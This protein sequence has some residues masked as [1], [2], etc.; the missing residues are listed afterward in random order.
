MVVFYTREI[1]SSIIMVCVVSRDLWIQRLKYCPFPILFQ[2]SI[3][4][5]DYCSF[6]GLQ[7][8]NSKKYN[9]YNYNHER[10]GQGIF[11]KQNLN[12]PNYTWHDKSILLE[13]K[14]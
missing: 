12:L 13:N 10:T 11:R 2:I 1:V 4:P 5:S 8:H 9:S 6:D 7:Y 3:V 14:W